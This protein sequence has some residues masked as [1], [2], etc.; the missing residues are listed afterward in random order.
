MRASFSGDSEPLRVCVDLN[1]D[2]A[3]SITLAD[4]LVNTAMDVRYSHDGLHRLKKAEEGTAGSAGAFTVVGLVDDWTSN[5]KSGGNAGIGVGQT[6]NWLKRARDD[7]PSGLTGGNTTS[8]F[9]RVNELISSE[10]SNVTISPQYSA[11]GELTDD[12]RRFSYKYDGWGR[13]TEVKNKATTPV[14][15]AEYRYNALGYRTG[16]RNPVN[17]DG[18][19][20]N[21]APW[22]WMVCNEC[23]QHIATFR[24]PTWAAGT[25]GTSEDNY[26][27]ET[28][29]HHE[30]GIDGLGGSSYIDGVILRDRDGGREVWQAAASA[31]RGDRLYYLQ[32]WRA[33]TVLTMRDAGQVVDRLA[34]LKRLAYI[35][36]VRAT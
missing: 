17:A 11:N 21:G 3:S 1:H 26:P 36:A 25:L 12:A 27:K 32:N 33:D 22:Y 13:L 6:G 28:F 19:V 8:T 29:I 30:A 5:G 9:N 4:D 23:W 35:H 7:A 34:Y 14:V 24:C 18:T 15:V 20:D 10:N 2:T 31:T 16:W